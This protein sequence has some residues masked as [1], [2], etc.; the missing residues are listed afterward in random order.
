MADLPAMLDHIRAKPDDEAG[1]LV[2]AA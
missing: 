2:L 1:W